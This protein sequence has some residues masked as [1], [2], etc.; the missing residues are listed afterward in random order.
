MTDSGYDRAREVKGASK[1]T[2]RGLALAALG[3]LFWQLPVETAWVRVPAIAVAAF[4]SIY[5]FAGLLFA[6]MAWRSILWHALQPG[7]TRRVRTALSAATLLP[8]FAAAAAVFWA[9]GALLA[10]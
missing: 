5:A 2:G 10:R 1:V 8:V 3:A 4:V 9:V 6:A 7:R